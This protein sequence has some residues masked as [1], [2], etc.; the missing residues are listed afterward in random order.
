[1]DEILNWKQ[2]LSPYEQAVEEL[3]VKFNYI[4]KEYEYRGIPC[5]IEIV[6]GRVKS[7]SSIMA[8]ANKKGI[9]VR[10]ATSYLE[11]IAGLRLICQF[12]EDIYKVAHHIKTRKDMVVSSEVDYVASP[13]PSGYRSYHIIIQYTVQTGFTNITIPVEI[14]IRT[15]A[16]NFWAVIEHSLAYKYEQ[17][18]P[19]EVRSRLTSAAE[20]VLALDHEMASIRSEILEAHTLF[21]KKANVVYDILDSLQSLYSMGN[22]DQVMELQAE[23]FQLYN[24]G[25]MKSLKEF[26]RRLE[27]MIQ[28][29]CEE[30]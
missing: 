7:I 24:G 19:V 22:Q 1:M 23:F 5:P 8:K 18:V 26:S 25:D 4:R 9:D 11:D 15:L 2:I 29:G 14:Q 10:E 28:N 20:A 16:M 13:K 21:R 27:Y 30:Q 6:D 3:K 17:D 12:T